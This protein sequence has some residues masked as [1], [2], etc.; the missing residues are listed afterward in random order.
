MIEQPDLMPVLI[1]S[2]AADWVSMNHK[3][4]EDSFKAALYKH[5]IYEKPDV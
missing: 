1:S 2:I 3:V 4:D 5:K